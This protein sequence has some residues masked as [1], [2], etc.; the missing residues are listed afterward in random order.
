MAK[1]KSMNRDLLLVCGCARSGMSL[2]MQE[3]AAGGY[4]VHGTFPA[5]EDMAPFVFPEVGNCA[6]KIP[7]PRRWKLPLERCLVLYCTRD[8]KVQ[9]K[10]MCRFLRGM[11]LPAYSWRPMVNSIREDDRVM[12]DR[13]RVAN[14]PVL[15]QSFEKA[16]TQPR[17]CAERVQAFVGR[18]FDIDAMVAA[19]RPRGPGLHPTLLELDLLREAGATYPA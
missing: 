9:A 17:A 18:T 12:F 16:V 5:Y 4:P 14:A 11:G 3:L 10:S 7:D 6:V 1:V 13:F 15:A 8:P 19:V 2:T